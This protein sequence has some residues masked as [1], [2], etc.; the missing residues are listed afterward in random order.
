MLFDVVADMFAGIGPFAV[1]AAMRGA[2][3][4][5]NDLNPQSAAWLRTNVDGN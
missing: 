3:V 1:P 4:Y 5:A 2:K